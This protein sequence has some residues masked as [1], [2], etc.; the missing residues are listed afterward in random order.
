[1]SNSQMANERSSMSKLSN[2]PVAVARPTRRTF[3]LGAATALGA[4]ATAS[5]GYALPSMPSAGRDTLVLVYLRGGLDGLSACVPRFEASALQALR[6]NLLVPTTASAGAVELNSLYALHPSLAPLEPMY[7]DGELAILHAAGSLDPTRSHFAARRA[8]EAGVTG[9]AVASVHGG[10]AGRALE[11]VRESTV[12]APRGL[13]L[14]SVL[15]RTLLGGPRVMPVNNPGAF[16]DYGDTGTSARRRAALTAMHGAALGAVGSQSIRSRIALSGMTAV[17]ALDIIGEI[18]FD[19]PAAPSAHYPDTLLGARL[20]DAAT[21]VREDIGTDVIHVEEG[22]WDDHDDMGP[23]NGA[24]ASRLDDLGRSLAAFRADLGQDL[25]RTTVLVYSEFGRRVDENGSGGTDHGRAGVAF[26]MGGSVHG[27][28][29]L[30]AWPGLSTAAL[31]DGALAVTTDL[32][33]VFAEVLERR[34]GLLNTG[35]A[36]PGHSRMPVGV[37]S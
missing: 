4:A 37:V 5:A 9:G 25:D 11:E 16:A 35:L 24:L 6:P 15:P 20:K 31:D 2:K 18:D 21:L 1:M 36:F 8:I 14:G 7:R 27:G 29:V 33:D 10:W 12:A 3:T 22:D 28:Q 34:M 32:R 17:G 23:V 13:A 26:A 30:G 19:R